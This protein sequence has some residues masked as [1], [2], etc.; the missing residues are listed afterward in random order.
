[1]VADDIDHRGPGALGIVDVRPAVQ[2]TRPKVQQ[3]HGRVA[4][5]AGMAIGRASGDPSNR[6][7]TDLIR[8]SWSSAVTR[9]ISDV[10]GLAK[11][12]VTPMVGQRGDQRFSARHGLNRRVGHGVSFLSCLLP[13]FSLS[14]S[15]INV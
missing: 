6:H 11:Q 13:V 9:C 15:R 2:V 10:P 7:R 3:C 1:M 12:A 4:G 8:G 14:A 5:D